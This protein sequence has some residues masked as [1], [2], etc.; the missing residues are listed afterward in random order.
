MCVYVWLVFSYSNTLPTSS[1]NT[2]IL[3]LDFLLP[4]VSFFTLN[5][6]QCQTST[7]EVSSGQS[8][9]PSVSVLHLSYYSLL[10]QLWNS[11]GPGHHRPYTL[12][13]CMWPLQCHFNLKSYLLIK[14]NS[15]VKTLNSVSSK[16]SKDERYIWWLKS[17]KEKF[18]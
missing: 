4:D 15:I 14:M 18:S 3:W 8:L 7:L 2:D 13:S 11:G 16:N 1:K 6:S 17:N 5:I 12:S 9:L 10:C